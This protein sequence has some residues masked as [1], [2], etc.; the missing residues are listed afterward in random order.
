MENSKLNLDKLHL[1]LVGIIFVGV[2]FFIYNKKNTPP[3]SQINPYQTQI[4]SL[5]SIISLYLDSTKILKGSYVKIIEEKNKQ[6]QMLDS[7]NR[8]IIKQRK[9]YEDKIKSVYM[10]SPTELY[11]FI[12][13][14]YK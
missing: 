2:I 7:L 14:R 13:N 4:D 1:I 10:Y 8:D 3:I 9:K 6:T 11:E 12:T 5:S